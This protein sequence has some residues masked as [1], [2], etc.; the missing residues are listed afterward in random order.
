MKIKERPE[1]FIVREIID[2]GSKTPG[3]EYI[4]FLMKKKNL[5]TIRAIR[6]VAKGLRISKKRIF[7]AGEKDKKT[8]SEQY[9]AIKGLKDFKQEY[10]FGNVKLRYIGSF[11][12]PLKISD[13]IFNEFEVTIRDVNDWER[14]RFEENVTIFNEGFFNYFDDQRFG[15][16]R[17]I[18][19]LIGRE[20]I[21]R[22]WE[23]AVKILL[24]YSSE[25]ENPISRDARKFLSE[26][27]GKFEEAIK[28]FP[29]WL[30]VELSILN[31][32]IKDKNY[33]KALKTIHKRLLKLFIH[34]YQSYIW[35]KVLSQYIKE[36]GN[37]L[38]TIKV[39]DENLY[40]SKD[41]NFIKG[42]EKEVLPAIGYDLSLTL[43]NEGFKRV[44]D[45]ILREEGLDLTDLYFKDKPSLTLKSIKR[46]IISKAFD[47]EY[48]IKDSVIRISFKLERGSFA[49]M[50]IKHLFS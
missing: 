10:N 19:H 9:I 48:D 43:L 2:L 42:L 30:D 6:I 41:K 28:Y 22:D 21:K 13:I 14:K 26:N 5:S 8:V 36:F 11:D 4:Y 29:K 32:L 50:F 45:E 12:E 1:D 46:K 40:I 49:T 24:T 39:A 15:N 44:Y 7:F 3:T 34:S 31:Y 27:W 37:D 17:Y 20:I 23:N 18:N 38:S 33:Y 16:I 25:R 47:L 35:N